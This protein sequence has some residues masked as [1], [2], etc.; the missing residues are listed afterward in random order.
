MKKYLIYLLIFISGCVP[1]CKKQS[2][3][4]T[5]TP[6]VPPAQINCI[7]TVWTYSVTATPAVTA[8][9]IAITY[10]TGSI[11]GSTLFETTITSSWSKSITI[12]ES[13]QGTTQ[14]SYP[15]TLKVEW[16]NK[17]SQS[18]N[19]S[20]H[21]YKNGVDAITPISAPL[22]TNLTPITSCQ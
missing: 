6:Y 13:L 19:I 22:V 2:N 15:I 17:G 7:G 14:A 1:A 3:A 18:T 21:I 4:P 11:W 9:S 16:L 12:T 10:A 5:S 20:I 8:G